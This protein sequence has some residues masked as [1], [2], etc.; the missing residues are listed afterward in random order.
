MSTNE[1]DKSH[2]EPS[3]SNGS[4]PPPVENVPLA[5]AERQIYTVNRHVK[6]PPF[7]TKNPQLWFH[8]LDA[9][10]AICRVTSEQVKFNYV[11]S[12]LDM[13]ILS[14]VSDIITSMPRDPYEA[15][16]NRLVASFGE[17]EEGRIKRLLK[18]VQLGDKRPSHLLQE[19]RQI[20]GNLVTEDFLKS[21]WMQQLPPPVRAVISASE[22]NVSV[23]AILADKVF[24][25]TNNGYETFAI[26]A[27]APQSQSK[28][29]GDCGQLSDL[30]K[31]I[32]SI[33]KQLAELQMQKGNSRNN[34]S[35]S[36]GRSNSQSRSRSNSHS[37]ND[38][39][40]W[41][42]RRFSNNATKCTKPCKFKPEN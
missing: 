23:L 18:E 20:A 5:E 31:Q 28:S 22:E 15:V 7:W 14:Q 40:C 11:I 34:R 6:V 17:S 16:K 25:V 13:E 12:A 3:K 38:E 21:L 10:F 33:A 19:M 24:E 36:R 26:S 39:I 27:K 8:Q 35:S 37:H 41:Y 4:A 9:Q 29:N 2:G 32:S 30:Q 42:H 1:E